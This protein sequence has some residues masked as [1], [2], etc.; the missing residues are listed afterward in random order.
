MKLSL[1]GRVVFAAGLLLVTCGTA[2]AQ[3]FGRNKIHYR[4][5]DWRVL[6]GEHVDLYFYP[7]E[8]ELAR[9]ALEYAE[10]SFRYLE[11]Q[12]GHSPRRRIP[13]I[14][15]ASHVD[16][17]QTNILPFIPPEQILGV[18][19][20]LKRRV[21][22]PFRGDYAQFK[23]TLRHEMVHAFH[24][25][26]MAEMFRQHPRRTRPQFPLW[27]TEGLAEFWSDGEDSIDEMLLRSLTVSGRLPHLQSM[28][29][30]RGGVEYPLGGALHRWLAANFG[31]WRVQELYHDIWKYSSF[32]DAVEDIYGRSLEEL[33]DEFRFYFR[34]R[35]FP[36]VNERAPLAVTASEMQALAIKPVAYR[37]PGEDVT[38]FL[39]L[40]PA[41]GYMTITSGAWHGTE[42][43][44]VV[45]GERDSDFESFHPFASRMDVREGVAIFSSRFHERDALY[46]W[47]LADGEL[48]GRYQFDQLVSIRSP[49]WEPSGRSVVFS[50]LSVAGY[51]DLYRLWLAEGRL[52]QLTADRFDDLDPSFSPDGSAIVFT[53]DR[54]VHGPEGGKNL[55]LLDL[56]TL[57]TRHLTY[58]AWV[59]QAPRW[60]ANG[61]IYFSSDREGV[62]DIYSVDRHGNGRRETH[63]LT[64]A[65]DPQYVAEESSLLFTGFEDLTWKIFRQRIDPATEETEAVI[66]L[67][68]HTE[69]QSWTWPELVE[70]EYARAVP[71]PYESKFTLDF[72]AAEG[73]FTPGIGNSQGALFIFSDLLSDNLLAVGISSFQGNGFGNFIDNFNG[74]VLY[75]NQSSRLNWGGGG[76]RTRGLFIE[77]DFETV[78]D[79]SSFGGFL[80]ARYPFSRYERIETQFRLERSDRLDFFSDNSL[81]PRRV[82]WLASNFVTYAKDNSL[83]LFT[84]PIDGERTNVTAGV[85]ND[86]SN[87]RFDSWTV[88]V[89]H[90]RYFRVGQQSSYAIRLLG[91]YS[92]GEFPRRIN[93]GGPLAL[94]G[95]PRLRGVSGTR[96]AL[97][98]QELRF[99]LT[100]FVSLGFPFGEVR[101]PGVQGALF[102]DLGGAWR[103][104][105]RNRGILGSTGLGLR[106][107]VVFPL[108]LR[109]DFGYRFALG[110]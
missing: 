25:S 31:G 69:E 1:A 85:T 35:Y 49:A 32:Q 20:F 62:F 77:G 18:T 55:F 16:F 89:D 58:G 61:R 46:F 108:I 103:E 14:V 64:G 26:I 52:E 75:I 41:R 11:S 28:T 33:N 98:N 104:R 56:V 82:G 36:S 10:E 8:D 57:R 22:L 43:E 76:F 29:F 100:N 107:P 60:A 80:V 73:A 78:F 97:L 88:S 94:R 37:M 105:S 101:F 102:V 44:R 63:T 109:L 3:A 92:G 12:F 86:L 67:A 50:G 110:N 17:E 84:G 5:F 59:D 65:F 70:G 4:D 2:N 79:E 38:R 96:V 24:L 54:T 23:H 51:T 27:W 48:A 39:Y 21:A 99:P 91:I 34:Q 106:M 71:T 87:G 6:P 68:S 13:L 93:V 42:R 9:V 7:E 53:S 74:S 47:D 19:E 45:T 15:Y 30:L 95:Y 66:V 81:G 40:S 83:W 72:A 90:R